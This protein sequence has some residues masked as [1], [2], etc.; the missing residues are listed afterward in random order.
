MKTQ[1]CVKTHAPTARKEAGAL[2][3]VASVCLLLGW[4][5]FWLVATLQP[6]CKL[7]VAAPHVASAEAV[8]HSTAFNHQGDAGHHTPDSSDICRDITIVAS[9]ALETAVHTFG[10]EQPAYAPACVMQEEY[11]MRRAIYAIEYLPLPPPRTLPFYQRSS[12]ILI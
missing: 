5:A 7:S 1:A 11:A 10:G 12:R 4:S 2:R 9:A 6:C 3:R 8:S